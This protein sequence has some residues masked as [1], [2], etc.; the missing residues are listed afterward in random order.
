[1]MTIKFEPASIHQNKSGAI[2]GV[3]YFDFGSGIQFPI[4]G[5]NDFVVVIANWWMSS[6]AEIARGVDQTQFRFMDGPYWI[7]AL[8]QGD[9]S[10]LLQCTEDRPGAGIVHESI[11][12]IEDLSSSILRFA[13]DVVRA[14]SEAKIKS[15]DLFELQKKLLADF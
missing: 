15:T 9:S 11:V 4:S 3:I 13:R 2:S 6:F 7:I 10:V 1:M 12:K 14:C 5:W 8:L